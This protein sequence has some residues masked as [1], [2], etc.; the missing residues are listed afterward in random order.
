MLFLSWPTIL[1]PSVIPKSNRVCPSGTSRYTCQSIL[2]SLLAIVHLSFNI[3]GS[4]ERGRRIRPC[5][6]IEQR[7]LSGEGKAEWKNLE[8][9][10]YSAWKPYFYTSTNFALFDYPLLARVYVPRNFHGAISL[11]SCNSWV[12]FQTRIKRSVF[13]KKESTVRYSSVKGRFV[14]F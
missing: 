1:F 5:R 11:F 4:R 7:G 13:Y 6:R 10:E 9:L 14:P 3:F 2:M 12:S 8:L